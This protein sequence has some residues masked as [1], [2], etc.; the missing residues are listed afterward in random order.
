MVHSIPPGSH[1]VNASEQAARYRAFRAL[2]VPGRPL[3]M[4]NAWDGASAAIFRAAGC[5]ALGSSSA[6]IA[7]ALGRR[8]GAAAVSR[9]EAI[10]N[11][12]L[13][14]RI[15]GLPVNGDLE[16]GF[17]P[18]PDDCAAT[19]RASI[20]AGLA[21][22]GIEDTTADPSDPIHAFDASVD[23]IRAAAR[24]AQ[25]RILLTGRTDVL[26]HGRGDLEE[27]VRRLRAFAD[28]GADA[29]F[30]PG[31]TDAASVR[32]VSE[33]VAPVPLNVLV[34]GPLAMNSLEEVAAAGAARIS[35]GAAP[36]RVALAAAQALVAESLG[37]DFR[38]MGRAL[39]TAVVEA[40][41][42]PTNPKGDAA[43]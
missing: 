6:A 10:A 1:A 38:S 3:V 15:S 42:S 39:P 36:Y 31:L 25:G 34:A 41:L 23:R 17:G 24:E 22:L 43:R 13:L 8:D 18:S 29:L 20:E 32:R 19:V 2:H 28:A 16:D 9:E 12:A 35:L 26:L 14:S 37:G 30:A 7:N 4:P 11:A 21:G 40:A 33:A 27:V 5:L